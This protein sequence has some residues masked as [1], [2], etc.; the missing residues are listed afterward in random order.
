MNNLSFGIETRIY[1]S[2]LIIDI[3]K[4]NNLDIDIIYLDNNNILQLSFNND[5]LLFTKLISKNK[6]LNDIFNFITT[7][8]I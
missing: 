2:D 5:L 8:L 3:I 6:E 4:S 7:E 1:N